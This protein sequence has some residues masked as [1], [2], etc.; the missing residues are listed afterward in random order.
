MELTVNE[1]FSGIGSQRKALENL[2]VKH[3]VVGISEID[4]P[5]IKSYEAI[6][7][8]TRNYGDIS[9]IEKLDYADFWTYSFPC[10]DISSLGKQQGINEN[11]RSGLLLQVE[12]LLNISK[13]HNELPKYL[14]LENV[15]RLTTK[16]FK[17]DFNRWLEKLKSLGYRNYWKV[18]NANETGIPQ[19]RKRVF[20]ISIKED[21]NTEFEFFESVETEDIRDYLLDGHEFDEYVDKDN[22]IDSTIKRGCKIEFENRYDDILECDKEIFD[23]R[24]KNRFSR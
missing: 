5:A 18:I 21:I 10:T 20:V 12:R 11:T 22:R 9:N 17:E 1:L 24:A 16:K 7:G 13:L 23:C 6:F 19:N 2:G 4:E 8:K 3:K 15:E 14:M